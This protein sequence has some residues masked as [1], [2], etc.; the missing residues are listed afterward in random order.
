LPLVTCPDI[1][2]NPISR[3]KVVYFHPDRKS[4]RQDFSVRIS[5]LN[6][7]Q[8][9]FSRAFSSIQISYPN[10]IGFGLFVNA[11]PVTDPGFG[12]DVDRPLWIRLDFLA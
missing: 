1:E 6:G 11:Q 4:H 12:Q 10:G 5:P 3:Q 2:K 7:F 8:T 9:S